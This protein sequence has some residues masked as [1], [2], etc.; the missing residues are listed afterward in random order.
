MRGAIGQQAK[1]FA[2][3]LNDE[4]L[5]KYVVKFASPSAH[6]EILSWSRGKKIKFVRDSAKAV[7]TNEW[8]AKAKEAEEA[9]KAEQL[10]ISDLVNDDK[11]ASEKENKG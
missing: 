4:D 1:A 10:K 2:R 9:A 11:H 8:N 3:S 6:E 7:F 5:D